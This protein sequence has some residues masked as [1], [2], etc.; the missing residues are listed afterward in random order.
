M[1]GA[2]IRVLIADSHFLFREGIKS[3]LAMNSDM[4]IVG[5]AQNSAELQ[6]LLPAIAPEVV[7]IDF[8]QPGYFCKA[9]LALVCET[10][11]KTNILV[12]ASN[13]NKEDI[14]YSLEYGVNTYI[15]KECGADEVVNAIY[16]AIRKEKFF[17]HKVLDAILEKT[18][19]QN[20]ENGCDPISLTDRE[21]EIVKLI[22]EGLT[23]KDIAEKL[24][25]SFHTI[26]THRKN[27]FRKAGITN[28]SELVRYAVR[29]GLVEAN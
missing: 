22:A 17:C 26:S 15:L 19:P 4:A 28:S 12:I 13:K 29:R 5:E 9:D 16:A 7:I 20:E 14:L 2:K 11:P 18:F 8:Q 25:L 3:L 21:V 10:A 27:I 23:T 1:K 24:F 6:I